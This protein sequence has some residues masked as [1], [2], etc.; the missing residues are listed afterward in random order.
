[1]TPKRQQLKDIDTPTQLAAAQN[2][3][4]Y[5]VA[6]N[7]ETFCTERCFVK[8]LIR[9]NFREFLAIPMHELR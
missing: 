7:H 2:T 3:S 4:G 5:A 8:K 9:T 6:G 1:M